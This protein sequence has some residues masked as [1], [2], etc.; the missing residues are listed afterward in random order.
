MENLFYQFQYLS[1]AAAFVIVIVA[2]IFTCRFV[3]NRAVQKYI[4]PHLKS[5]GLIYHRY[6]WVGLI[7]TGD[8]DESTVVIRPTISFGAPKV[9]IYIY[10]YYYTKQSMEDRI[11]ARIDTLFMFIRKV[12]YSDQL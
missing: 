12:E 10:V 3:I 6:K 5:K 11:T 2:N 9:S 4:V 8:F 1:I 7:G